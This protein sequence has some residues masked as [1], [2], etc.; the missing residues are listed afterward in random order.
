M[1]ISAGEGFAGLGS[2]GPLTRQPASTWCPSAQL[3]KGS[4]GDQLTCRLRGNFQ[5][6]HSIRRQV[7]MD[8]D[9]L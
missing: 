5:T 1:M 9:G 2:C 8:W 7:G 6:V 4:K 3:G